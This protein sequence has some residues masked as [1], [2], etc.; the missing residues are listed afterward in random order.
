M[1]VLAYKTKNR[2]VSACFD[3]SL[4]RDPNIWQPYEESL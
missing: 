3:S 1:F 2:L 4:G